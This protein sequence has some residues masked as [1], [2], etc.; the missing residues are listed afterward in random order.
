MMKRF[1]PSLVCV[2][3]HKVGI[4]SQF[5]LFITVKSLNSYVG[6]CINPVCH[7]VIHNQYQDPLSHL[8]RLSFHFE[9]CKIRLKSPFGYTVPVAAFIIESHLPG[10]TSSRGAPAYSPQ[11]SL[12]WDGAQCSSQLLPSPIPAPRFF[13]QEAVRRSNS[14]CCSRPRGSPE[15]E[16]TKSRCCCSSSFSP[17]DWDGRRCEKCQ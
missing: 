1:W 7:V 17:S 5:G 9:I 8:L 10:P 2:T 14:C 4:I 16:A 15:Q 6:L 11:I 3:A 13:Q 12:G